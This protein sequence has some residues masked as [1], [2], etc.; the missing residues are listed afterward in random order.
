MSHRRAKQIRKAILPEAPD[1]GSRGDL[2]R[3]M[4]TYRYKANGVTASGQLKKY[5]LVL[6]TG[7]PR[8]IAQRMK[9]VARGL[10]RV[11]QW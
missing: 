3:A 5:S 10:N 2:F 9:G 1:E 8:A 4:T 7:T 6:G 11:V